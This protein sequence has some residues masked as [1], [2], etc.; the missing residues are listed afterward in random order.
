MMEEVPTSQMTGAS[1]LGNPTQMGLV[2][3][4]PSVAPCGA[5][6]GDAFEAMIA[7]SPCAVAISA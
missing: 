4:R 7:T 5:T 6:H 3:T 2:P 1:A